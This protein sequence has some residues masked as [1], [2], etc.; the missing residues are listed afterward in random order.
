MSSSVRGIDG[1]YGT[2]TKSL[3]LE[4][5]RDDDW[6]V[7][8]LRDV[9][10]VFSQGQTLAELEDNIRDAY[11]FVLEDLKEAAPIGAEL[12]EIEIAV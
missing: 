5:W 10:G 7:G 2:L 4:F 11:L 1:G 6:F 9:P 3:M 8:R 12:K